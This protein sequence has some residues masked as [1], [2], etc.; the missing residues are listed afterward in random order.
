MP[1]PRTDARRRPA[2]P[3]R[4]SVPGWLPVTSLVIA[5]AGL[6]VAGYLTYEH[7]TASTTLACPETGVVNCQKVT[8]SAQSEVFGIPVTLLGLLFFAPMVVACLPG[9]WRSPHPLV[10][11][12]RLAYAVVGIGFVGYLVYA[13]LFILDAICLWCTAVHG[14]TFALFAV[15]AFG[16]A[17][18]APEPEGAAP[19]R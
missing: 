19:E 6:L 7:F 17:S 16:T 5:V 8:T 9:F 4:P 10:R 11:Y 15:I 3:A 1:S 18:T 12:G 13:E 2:G 14:L